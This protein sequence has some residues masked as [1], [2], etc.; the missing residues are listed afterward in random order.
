MKP[1]AQKPRTSGRGA[2]TAPDTDTLAGLLAEAKPTSVDG[3]MVTRNGA[4]ISLSNWRGYGARLLSAFPNSHGYPAVKVKLPDGKTRKMLIHRE[5]C[6][7][8]HGPKPSP[9]H[10][11]R[12]LNGDRSD[13]R[14]DNLS[15]GT[16]SENAKDRMS[17]GTDAGARNGQSSA[18]KISGERSPRTRLSNHDAQVIRERAAAGEG[19]KSISFDFPHAS[20]WAVNRVARGETFTNE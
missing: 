6:E 18:H 12:H 2:V 16:R 15:W 13:N 11:V 20:Y 14:P 1:G 7:A 5:V 3:Y 17:H 4:V 9:L 10:E 8:F 19:A